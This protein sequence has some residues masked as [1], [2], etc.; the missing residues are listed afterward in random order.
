MRTAEI[1]QLIRDLKDENP[2]SGV[3]TQ[4]DSKMVIIDEGDGGKRYSFSAGECR[5][6]LSNP[7]SVERLFE[8]LEYPEEAFVELYELVVE[9][10]VMSELDAYAQTV[11]EM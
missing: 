8:V 6:L 4:E 1:E 5:L 11:D 3:V 2:V 9:P 7:T 10:E